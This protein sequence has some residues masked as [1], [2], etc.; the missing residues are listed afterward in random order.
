MDAI[1][2]DVVTIFH[3][4]RKDGSALFLHP[5][6]DLERFLEIIKNSEIE[7]R[8]GREPRVESFTLFRNDL[9]RM[10]DA[11]V[12]RWISE[13]RFIPRFLASAGA[14]LV[15]YLL[16]SFAFGDPLPLAEELAIGLGA[17]ALSY[18]VLNRIDMRS[19]AVVKK[20]QD[21]RARIDRIFFQNDPFLLE[22]EN[23]LDRSDGEP[24]ERIL[25]SILGKSDVSLNIENEREAVQLIGYL[26]RK[27]TRK[28]LRRQEHF[29]ARSGAHSESSG[30]ATSFMRW[31][32]SRKIDLSL[33]A[34]Y[35]QM[36]KSL[37]PV[38]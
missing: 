14:F 30:E 29:L 35:K 23:E 19:E 33:Y 8:Y 26:E 3:L 6:D 2:K 7:G 32:E 5:F 24:P 11:A 31:A 9:Y 10:I 13:T 17:G 15:S 18:I 37:K 28:D 12:R 25:D 20:T 34:L 1:K 27:F 21:L 16:F 38:I 22:V 4:Y 36:K